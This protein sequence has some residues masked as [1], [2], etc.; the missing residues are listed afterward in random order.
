[1]KSLSPK[2]IAVSK[3]WRAPINATTPSE[4]GSRRHGGT[5]QQL[6]QTRATA[7]VWSNAVDFTRRRPTRQ[8]CHVRSHLTRPTPAA[9]GRVLVPRTHRQLVPTQ[10]RT[11]AKT[12][13]R[14]TTAAATKM[15]AGVC[16]LAP[17]ARSL[18]QQL[19]RRTAAS[20]RNATRHAASHSPTLPSVGSAKRPLRS[21]GGSR[22]PTPVERASFS[23]RHVATGA[24][25]FR[26]LHYL[27]RSL[28]TLRVRRRTA[29]YT[30]T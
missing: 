19:H 30:R 10:R 2:S 9:G 22:L 13:V 1:M 12:T 5:M 24:S 17:P 25:L 23:V 27:R 7:A 20:L 14:P 6:V 21:E 3:I 4:D 18:A 28:H 26:A 29:V 15:V 8:E 11:H 16:R